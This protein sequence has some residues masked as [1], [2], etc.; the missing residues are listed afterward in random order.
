MLVG[1][2]QALMQLLLSFAMSGGAARCTHLMQHAGGVGAHQACCLSSHCSQVTSERFVMISS[3]QASL[4][5]STGMV[6]P[7]SSQLIWQ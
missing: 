3:Q 5:S 2:K 1:P 4:Q 7:G 6:V